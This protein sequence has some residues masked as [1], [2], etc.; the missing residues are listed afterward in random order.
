LPFSDAAVD[1]VL[2]SEVIEHIPVVTL[3]KVF[4]E[5]YR[6]SRRY[7]LITV[8]YRE[9]LADA[10]VRCS[11]GF[12]FHK[13][14][15]IQSFDENKVRSIYPRARLLKLAYIGAPKPNDPPLL[16]TLRQRWAGRYA[17]ADPDTL[18]PKCGGREF[19]TGSRNLISMLLGG[20]TLV[21]S[22]TLSPR[23]ATWIGGLFEKVD[24]PSSSSPSR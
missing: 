16:K 14:G 15:H 5:I 19:V 23:K 9:T 4:A 13:W 18:C 1:L 8:P 3:P 12:V 10:V 7:I 20:A 17:A 2:A 11:C 24:V 6:V 21:A 22:R